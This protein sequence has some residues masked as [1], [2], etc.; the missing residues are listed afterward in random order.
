MIIWVTGLSGAGKTTLCSALYDIM[1]PHIP[2]LV[3]LDGDAVRKAFGND[4][5]YSEKERQTQLKRLQNLTKILSSQGT[6]VLVAVLYSHPEFLKWNREN[7]S[8]YFEI[9]LSVALD[10]LRQRDEK[11][12]YTGS[13]K[14]VVGL[15]V[16]WYPPENPNLKIEVDYKTPPQ[17]LALE[18]ISATPKLA[19]LM[20][21]RLQEK[22]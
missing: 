7:F 18:V 8:E 1:K 6:I 2:Q 17:K 22:T 3:W 5:G 20:E 11:G 10:V 15:D 13:I 9:Y 21:K 16:P 19:A 4:L 12:L 14:N